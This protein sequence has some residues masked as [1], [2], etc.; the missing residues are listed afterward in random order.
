MS[1]APPAV[2][3]PRPHAEALAHFPATSND[4]PVTGG[5]HS[6]RAREVDLTQP[7]ATLQCQLEAGSQ[8]PQFASCT[9]GLHTC[10][11]PVMTTA[12][13]TATPPLNHPS[14]SQPVRFFSGN[15]FL[16]N[17]TFQNYGGTLFSVAGE[18]VRYHAGGCREDNPFVTS[19]KGLRSGVHRLSRAATVAHCYGTNVFHFFVEILPR[20]F[21]LLPVLRSSPDVAIVAST[22]L[23]QWAVDLWFPEDRFSRRLVVM[24]PGGRLVHRLVHAR[25]MFV[26]VA[27]PCGEAVKPQF[28]VVRDHFF[29]RVLPQMGAGL[30]PIPSQRLLLLYQ[31]PPNGSR[32]FSEHDALYAEMQRVYGREVVQVF[33]G[34]YPDRFQGTLRLL[35]QARLLVGP[36][37]AGLT[38]TVFLPPT[39]AVL[40]IRP[41]RYPNPCYE[42]VAHAC[43]LRYSVV[44]A[45]GGRKEAMHVSVATVMSAMAGLFPHSTL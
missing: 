20:Y 32:A 38:A 18:P 19:A 37:G 13:G 15:V 24:K 27:F 3:F 28:T 9:G 4:A 41:T 22:E 29:T 45:S 36:H 8:C 40:E 26:P 6:Y 7:P 2:Q 11:N 17:N 1:P 33:H 25:Q 34:L 39:A 30:P 42:Y 16:L 44:K 31:R 12:A 10:T 23:W 35:Q 43:G 5:F 21:Q 14:R